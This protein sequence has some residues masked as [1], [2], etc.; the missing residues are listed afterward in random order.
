MRA[1]H[2]LLDL[3]VEGEDHQPLDDATIFLDG[4]AHTSEIVR[5]PFTDGDEKTFAVY[6]SRSGYAFAGPSSFSVSRA[7]IGITRQLVV[8]MRPALVQCRVVDENGTALDALVRLTP[9]SGP[10]VKDNVDV[11]TVYKVDCTLR[12][13]RRQ[14]V[15]CDHGTVSRSGD[16]FCIAFTDADFMRSSEPIQIEVTMEPARCVIDLSLVEETPTDSTLDTVQVDIGQRGFST[17]RR[18]S[19]SLSELPERLA[20]DIKATKHVLVGP[21]FMNAVE[22]VVSQTLCIR[23]AL[24]EAVVYDE[25]HT[26]V[27]GAD[28]WLKPVDD[29]HASTLIVLEAGAP[30]QCLVELGREYAVTCRKERLNCKC[31]TFKATADQLRALAPGTALRLEVNAQQTKYASVD[32][33]V[34]GLYD[35]GSGQ[36][37]PSKL[38]S[39]SINDVDLGPARGVREVEAADTT[40]S[41][42]CALRGWAQLPPYTVPIVG[43]VTSINLEMVPALIR[44]VADV[45]VECWLENEGDTIQVPTIGWTRVQVDTSYRLRAR[46]PGMR[47]ANPRRVTFTKEQ[48]WEASRNM[49]APPSSSSPVV[50][51]LDLVLEPSI[52]EL[53]LEVNNDDCS[54]TLERAGLP[55]LRLERGSQVVEGLPSSRVSTVVRASLKGHAQLKP[56]EPITLAAA[57]KHAVSIEMRPATVVCTCIDARTG[58]ELVHARVRYEGDG[59]VQYGS[60]RQSVVV[61]P[62]HYRGCVV[63]ERVGDAYRILRDDGSTMVVDADRLR[64]SGDAWSKLERGPPPSYVYEVNQ[65][66]LH[67]KRHG[68]ITS[69][70]DTTYRVEFE[71][72]A[73][74]VDVSRLK[75]LNYDFRRHLPSGLKC[76]VRTGG[77]YTLTAELKGWRQLDYTSPHVFENEAFVAL[78]G[79][80]KPEVPDWDA[81]VV[82]PL[83][84][85]SK[86]LW[87]RFLKPD[88]GRALRTWHHGAEATRASRSLQGKLVAPPLK[89]AM[90]LVPGV[91][92]VD[93][94]VTCDGSDVDADIS[95]IPVVDSKADPSI[96]LG[97]RRGIINGLAVAGAGEAA[98]YKVRAKKFG[99]RVME[100]STVSLKAGECTSVSVQLARCLAKVNLNVSGKPFGGDATVKVVSNEVVLASVEATNGKCSVPVDPRVACKLVVL[101]DRHEQISALKNVTWTPADFERGVTVDIALKAIAV[102]LDVSVEDAATG[103]ELPAAHVVVGGIDVGTR[104]GL[105]DF[106]D[107]SQ[108]GLVRMSA[109]LQG[110]HMLPPF[111]VEL[112]GGAVVNVA[113]RLRRFEVVLTAAKRR[114]GSLQKLASADVALYHNGERV[115]SSDGV[116]SVIP[117]VRYAILAKCAGHRQASLTEE[118]VFS[119]QHFD[120]GLSDRLELTVELESELFEALVRV[121]DDETGAPLDGAIIQL[122]GFETCGPSPPT[123]WRRVGKKLEGVAGPAVFLPCVAAAP[124]RVQ[125]STARIE[126]RND[127]AV[128]CTTLRLRRASIAVRVLDDEGRPVTDPVVQVGLSSKSPEEVSTP[129]V[130]TMAL[131]R[132]RQAPQYVRPRNEVLVVLDHFYDVRVVHDAMRQRD[133][134]DPQRFEVMDF[135]RKRGDAALSI[136]M[137]PY[138]CAVDLKVVDAFGDDL[139]RARVRLG[140]H[141][142]GTRRGVLDLGPNGAV[143]QPEEE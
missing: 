3:R 121:V 56:L 43:D 51:S 87:T 140:D 7:K 135:G 18:W 74:D 111:D 23:P 66:V 27:E 95:L 63:V 12:K 28:V 57:Q 133:L 52:C 91:G 33:Q 112:V 30:Q 4:E 143:V 97:E 49:E 67:G 45:D 118:V 25:D 126:L 75:P 137:E 89:L 61:D 94:H 125:T 72:G 83:S 70:K 80:V 20:I 2:S 8:R 109:S 86:S 88:L 5:K 60:R 38:A 36:D 6:G 16:A 81:S 40:L 14:G 122:D 76:E 141:D 73:A 48:F 46:A 37:D 32:V 106:D 21:T 69:I 98:L 117:G 129:R 19:A 82:T 85:S 54:L 64:G 128:P 138:R 90:R 59:E 105:V 78:G 47:L 99:Y 84:T 120:D 10:E 110:Y 13:Y 115:P 127:G 134:L 53:A 136:R 124:R 50:V 102:T 103:A 79:P 132:R 41:T 29:V 15:R 17:D 9:P 107:L 108:T 11:D 39:V 101:A 58:S 65:N 123:G 96:I 24:I 114:N 116:Y 68:T 44:A 42:S 34:R 77:Q 62:A 100:P 104:R 119:P 22:D 26:V 1:T 113:L 131:D 55:D 35:V 31:A 130:G 71:D 139:P 92:S 142:L 93:L